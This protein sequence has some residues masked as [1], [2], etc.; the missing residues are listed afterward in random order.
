MN[1]QEMVELIQRYVDLDLAEAEEQILLSH[2]KE[3]PECAEYFERLKLFSNELKSLPKVTPP[4]SIVNAVLPKL[5]EMGLFPEEGAALEPAA[6][7]KRSDQ[8]RSSRKTHRAKEQSY[9]GVLQWR[10]ALGGMA[11]GIALG[12]FLFSSNGAVLQQRAEGLLMQNRT[13]DALVSGNK[14]NAANKTGSSAKPG[15]SGNAG[16][17]SGTQYGQAASNAPGATPKP[18]ETPSAA[19][20]PQSPGDHAA[21]GSGLN[22]S[23][24][25]AEPDKSLNGHLPSTVPAAPSETKAAPESASPANT[26]GD[27]SKDG[28]KPTPAPSSNDTAS[29]SSKQYDI[30]QPTPTPSAEFSAFGARGFAL[31]M[32][33]P[34]PADDHTQL[35]S[36]SGTYLAVIKDQTVLVTDKNGSEV[37]RS[38]FRWKDDDAIRLTAWTDAGKLVYLVKSS[39]GTE[40]SFTIDAAAKTETKN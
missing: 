19:A 18:G 1:C 21:L 6:G 15:K 25:T 40:T 24:K 38:Q 31:P 28:A 12:I 32:P 30:K 26:A 37:F 10:F 13:S 14:D 20:T 23:P 17:P 11:A 2:L 5:K 16:A 22:N 8:K 27:S 7:L 36:P 35:T 39:D 9:R 4:Y 33:T 29:S 3:C 34:A